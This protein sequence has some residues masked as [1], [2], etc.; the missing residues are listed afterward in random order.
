MDTAGRWRRIDELFYAALDLEPQAR[1]AFLAE[2]CGTDTALLKEVGSLLDASEHT[3]GYA[4]SAVL[5]LAR[6]Q[7]IEPQPAGKQVGDY[8]LL[9]IIGE[10]GMGTVY[11]AARADDLYRQHVAVKLMHPGFGSSR[12]MLIRFSAERQILANL[13][14]PNIARLLD[15]GMTE[16]GVPYL[17]MEFVDGIRIDDYCRQNHLSVEARLELFRSVCAA[18]EYAH[19]HLVIHRDIKPAN[20]LV[21][22]EGVPKLLDFGIAKLLDPEADAQGLTRTGERLMTPEYASPEQVRGDPITTASDVYS[23]GVLLY[24]LLAG[25]EP[26]ELQSMNILQIAEVVCERVPDPP[27]RAVAANSDRCAPD[28]AR[29]VKGDLDN[30][31]LMAMRKEPSRRYTSAGALSHDLQAYLTGYSVVAHTDT[32]RYRTAKFVRRHRLAVSLGVA[33]ALTLVGFSAAMGIL[34]H[35]ANQARRIADQQ[36]LEARLEADFLASIFNASAPEE[37]KGNALTAVELL[38]SSA[39]RIDT[40]L[41]LTPEAQ[42]T[43]LFNL[44]VAYERLG[45]NAKAEPLLERAYKIRMKIL[46][47]KSFDVAMT[48]NA[49]GHAF[50]EAGRYSEADKLLVQ[51]LESAEQAPGNNA[52]V[53]SKMQT[54]L[55][56]CLW[57]ESRDAESIAWFRKSLALNP[58]PDGSDAQITRALLA[59]A[60]DRHGELSEAWQLANNAARTLERN[61]GPTFHLAIARHIL[62]KL[63][64]DRGDLIETERA[65]RDTLALWRKTGGSHIDVIYAEN[66]LGAILVAEGDWRQAEPLLQN[67]LTTRQNELGEKHPLVAISL[68]NLGRL[69]EAKGDYKDAE[70]DFSEAGEM[71][72]ETI[73][74]EGW[75]QEDVLESLSLLKLDQGDYAGAEDYAR[76][77]LGMTEN[78]GAHHSLRAGELM[79]DIGLAREFQHDAAGAEPLFRQAIEVDKAILAPGSPA[80]TSAET[81]LGEA[82]IIQGKS[83]LAE[84]LL[85]D[86][87]DSTRKPPFPLL[88]WQVAEPQYAL[89]LCLAKLGRTE[90]AELLLKNSREALKTYPDP[91]LRRWILLL[92]QNTVHLKRSVAF[93][94]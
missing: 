5:Q 43:S 81:R 18:V 82:L 17:V 70:K 55:A 3:L 88:P 85:R 28:A 69:A 8:K 56:Y 92:S 23:L 9:G 65:E 21:T 68:L 89:G 41:A 80:L 16:E 33:A 79:D 15:G 2:A 36:R 35:R 76:K 44:G 58:D 7:T 6:Q 25:S 72:N 53:V 66:N 64:L 83:G 61:E 40:E 10:G 38:D 71:L 59:Q 63:M 87:V 57:L 48:A 67:S 31:V 13:N 60:L 39:K 47:P 27:S 93:R 54:D 46:G 19:K 91:A 34:A 94:T 29:K 74:P 52:A 50:Q 75:N 32:W 49:L 24:Q 78:L 45:M 62:A 12:G 30:I 22:A 90:E 51:S 73:G 86:A 20:I 14:H 4:Q 1:S 37:S 42:A 11:L 84:P 77:A 26:F